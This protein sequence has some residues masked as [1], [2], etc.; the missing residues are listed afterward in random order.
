[1]ITGPAFL[2]A[3]FWLVRD[4]FRQALASRVFWIMLTVTGVC[5]VFCLGVSVEG[6][7]AEKRPEDIELFRKQKGQPDPRKGLEPFTGKTDDPTRLTLL[8]GTVRNVEV[9]RYPEEAVHLL[10]V[11]LASYVA[12]TLGVLLTLVW[13][14]GFL[15]DFLQPSAASVLFAKPVP[16]WTILLGKYIGVV[17]FV[18]FQAVVFFGCTWLALGLRTNVWIYSYLWAA[19]L[20]VLHFAVV[21]TFSA[22]LA[23]WTRST[24]ATMFGSLLFWLLCYAMNLGHHYAAALPLLTPGGMALPPVSSF[25]TEFGYWFLPKPLDFGVIMEHATGVPRFFQ[26]MSSLD[27]VQYLEQQGRFYPE[28]SLLSSAGFGVLMLFVACRQLATTDY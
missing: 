18:A 6:G 14:A 9:G 26:S 12:G 27:V 20:L 19:P 16:R 2:Y 11:I 22:V 21:F 10:L 5:T 7:L 3:L 24:V 1:V 23:V 4:T 17:T 13:T 15:P 25:L 8:F 28:L